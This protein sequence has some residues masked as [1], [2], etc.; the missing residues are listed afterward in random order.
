MC[1]FVCENHPEVSAQWPLPSPVE[2]VKDE[3]LRMD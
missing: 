3:I 2:D 1:S